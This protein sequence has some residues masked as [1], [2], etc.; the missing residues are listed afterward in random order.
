MGGDDPWI[1]S[2]AKIGEPGVF[3]DRFYRS[4]KSLDGN[5]NAGDV[6]VFGYDA[7]P[8]TRGGAASSAPVAGYYGVTSIRSESIG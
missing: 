2:N 5:G 3:T 8:R 6:M 4:R 1:F 7:C